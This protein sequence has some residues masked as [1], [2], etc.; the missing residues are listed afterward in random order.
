MEKLYKKSSPYIAGWCAILLFLLGGCPQTADAPESQPGEESSD[1]Q[2][3]P[4]EETD[5]PGITQFIIAGIAGLIDEDTKTITLILPWGT[6][7]NSL[8]PEITLTEGAVI[9]PPSGEAQDFTG[10]VEYTL[11]LEGVQ[12]RYQVIV[13][14]ADP[15]TSD[16]R[17]ITSFIINGIPGTIEEA[18]KTITLILPF[19]TDLKALRPEIGV[20]A[21]AQVSPLSGEAQ[22]FTNAILMPKKYRVT[23]ENGM[24]V[25]YKVTVQTA[26]QNS[27]TLVLQRELSL[28]PKSVSLSKAK[29]ESV[30]VSAAK[31]YDRYQWYIDG[32]PAGTDSR[33]IT[34]KAADYFIGA[35]YLSDAVDATGNGVSLEYIDFVKVQTGLNK[36]D[37]VTHATAST[38]VKTASAVPRSGGTKAQAATCIEFSPAPGQFVGRGNGYSNPVIPNLSSL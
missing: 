19:G 23:A 7:L 38:L 14:T 11:T 22:N 27:F 5:P 31:D 1:P 20:S 13:S 35:H 3:Q 30:S 21:Q 24:Q 12:T 6:S 25:E 10:P 16:A 4:D 33:T 28:S 15:N 26:A 36:G 8:S 18:A 32:K 37:G 34:L 29:A 9:S 2:D 17:A